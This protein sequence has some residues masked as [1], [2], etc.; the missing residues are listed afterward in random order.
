MVDEYKKGKPAGDTT[1]L[2]PESDANRDTPPEYPYNNV[3]ETESGHLFELDDTPG[4]ERVRLNHRT[5]TFIEMQADGTE[6]HKIVGDGYEIIA[7][8]KNVLIEG[9]C[10]ITIKGDCLMTVEGNKKER[11]KGNYELLVDGNFTQVVQGESEIVSEGDTTIGCNQ[12]LLGTLRLA[13]GDQLYVDGDLSVGGSIT[14]DIITSKTRVDAGTGVR[15]GAL[16]FVSTT[17]GLSIGVPAAAPFTIV[18][19]GSI[20]A[21]VSMNS[22]LGLWGVSRAVLMTDSINKT[23][24]NVHRHPKT[25]RARPKFV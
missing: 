14:G 12:S 23:I 11:V 18:C 2:E 9:I 10:N 15:A 20:F 24:F 7:K 16:G 13:V 5:G 8:D 6:V 17:G 1:W 4:R 22:P 19:S 3:T 25:G 21:G